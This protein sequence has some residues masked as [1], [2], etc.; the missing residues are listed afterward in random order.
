MDRLYGDHGIK[1]FPAG[2]TGAQMGGWFKRKL[3]DLSDL[4][5]LK[6]RIPGLGGKVMAELGVNV[7]VLPGGEIYLALE[8]GAID[9]AE[10]T[11]PYDDAKLG[12]NRAASLLLLPGLVGTRPHPAP[13][14]EPRRLRPAAGGIPGDA[15]GGLP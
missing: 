15:R 7:Q 14:G 1:A 8:R 11:G 2:N 13:V 10:W 6:M 5:G 12:L 9:A 3:E 4:Q